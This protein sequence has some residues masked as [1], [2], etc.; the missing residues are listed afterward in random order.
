LRDWQ[1]SKVRDTEDF[2]PASGASPDYPKVGVVV[3]EVPLWSVE[4]QA[5]YIW[6]RIDTHRNAM[7]LDDD[8]LPDCADEERWAKPDTWAVMKSR[9]KRAIRVLSSEQD[10]I[11]YINANELEGVGVINRPGNKTVKCDNYC[12]VNTFCNQYRA[13]KA[14]S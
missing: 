12:P 11:D 7:F 2:G 10:A 3:R 6:G 1:I 13:L 4:K 14:G 8:L 9:A 5:E